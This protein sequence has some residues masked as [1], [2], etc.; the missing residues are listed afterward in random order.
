MNK[1]DRYGRTIEVG[2]WI[3]FSVSNSI[4]SGIVVSF[5]KSGTP[6]V[7]EYAEYW[8]EDERS[9]GMPFKPFPKPAGMNSGFIKIE[10]IVE[11]NP[12]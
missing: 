8:R 2:D 10:P 9:N 11:D 5:T 12:L 7:L 4:I 1:T 6:R 3:A